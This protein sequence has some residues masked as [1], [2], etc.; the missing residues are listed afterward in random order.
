MVVNL[1]NLADQE[2]EISGSIPL[3]DMG[4]DPSRAYSGS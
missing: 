1:F 4:V 2:R 3:T